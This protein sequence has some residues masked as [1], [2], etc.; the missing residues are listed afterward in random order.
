MYS[1]MKNNDIYN[2]KAKDKKMYQKRE[3]KFEDYKNCSYAS[4][5]DNEI[6]ILKDGNYN[7]D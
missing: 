6:K 5:L 1:C 3:I 4:K 7:V 2:K